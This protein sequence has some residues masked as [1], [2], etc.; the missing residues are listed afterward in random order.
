MSQVECVPA[1]Q[2][3]AYAQPAVASAPLA[4]RYAAPRPTEHKLRRLRVAATG[5]RRRR[6]LPKGQPRHPNYGTGQKTRLVPSLPDL[7]RSEGL[8]AAQSL[9][10]AEQ[11]MLR[12]K[13]LTAYYHSI[14]ES[15]RLPKK[16]LTTS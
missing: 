14:Q 13:G 9:R 6:G 2:P 3:A 8:P 12:Q 7:L 4:Y 11:R 16:R 15:Y 1:E 10:D 5:T